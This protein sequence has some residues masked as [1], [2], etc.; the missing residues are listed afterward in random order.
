MGKAVM[1]SVNP[2]YSRWLVEYIKKIEWRKEILPSG[3][4]FVY[5]TKKKG[6]CGK[7]IGEI[8]VG[9]SYYLDVNRISGNLISD[10]MVSRELLQ[11][12]SKGTLLA[13]NFIDFAVEYE[14]PEDLSKFGLKRPPQSWQYVEELK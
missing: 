8:A 7:V 11:K 9:S 12:Y 4:T 10:G 1:I 3:R 13:A 5:E 14:N 2:P 6:G